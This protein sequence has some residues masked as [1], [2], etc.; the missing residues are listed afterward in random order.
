MAL[1]KIQKLLLYYAFFLFS[2]C[3]FIKTDNTTVATFIVFTCV[4]L[5]VIEFELLSRYYVHFLAN[6]LEK[7][8]KPPVPLANC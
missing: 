5:E 4:C 6:T 3:L 2:F 8:M 7:G 1:L